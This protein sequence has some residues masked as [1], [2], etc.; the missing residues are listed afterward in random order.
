M[1][2]LQKVVH[3]MQ[4]GTGQRDRVFNALAL[5]AESGELANVIKK[6][7]YYQSCTFTHVDVAQ[8]LADVLF[9]VI[10]V[11]N[12]FGYSI[13]E[14]EKIAVEKHQ[15]VLNSMLHKKETSK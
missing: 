12:D 13:E 5:C 14:I 7:V 15:A 3:T 11:A 9:H 8:E 6:M 2:E 4:F 1:D 10:G